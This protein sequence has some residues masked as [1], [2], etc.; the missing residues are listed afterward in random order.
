VH[1]TDITDYAPLRSGRI[2]LRFVPRNG[3]ESLVVVQDTPRSPGIYG[4]S[5]EFKNPGVYDLSILVDSPQAKDSIF[6]PGLRVYATV[7]EAPKDSGEEDAGIP[8]LKEQQ[9]KT[10]RFRTDFATTGTVAATFEATGEIEPAAGR[11]AV[12]AAPIAGLVDASSVA[13]SP[14]PGQRVAQGQV[15]VALTPT[16]GD[17]G[18]AYAEARARLREAEDEDARA[19]RLLAAQAIPERRVHEAANRLQAA[20]EALAG[21][22]GGSLSANGTIAV[23]APIAGIVVARQVVPGSRV[24]AGAALFTIIDAS[25]LWLRAHV[26]AAQGRMISADMGATFRIEGSADFYDVRR[27]ISSGTVI[28]PQ[29]RTIPV[30]YETANADNKIRIGAVATVRLRTG[31]STEGVLIPNS[32]VLDEDGRPIAYVQVSGERFEKRE[33]TV[34][35][36]ENGRTAVTAGIKAGERVVTSAAY[37]VRL[38]SLSTSVPAHGHEH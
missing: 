35:G 16:I 20:R 38:A 6:V 29:S 15:L 27:M 22:A 13:T 33:L 30:L 11:E 7:A 34:V 2:T 14:V 25:T 8:F 4:P 18:S 5:P 10:P 37:Q 9:W 21:F 32:A 31:R 1:L 23:R 36:S 12:V 28:D 24:D 19:K 26:P 17:G 3:G